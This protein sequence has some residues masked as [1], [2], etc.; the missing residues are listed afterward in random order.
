MLLFNGQ[1]ISNKKIQK[2]EIIKFE[3][4]NISL[5][6]LNTTTIKKSQKFRKL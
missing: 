2:N 6:N 3:K 4:L 1:I 5:A